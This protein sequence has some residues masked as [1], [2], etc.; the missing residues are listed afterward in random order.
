MATE[1]AGMERKAGRLNWRVALPL[2][3][4]AGLGG[5]LFMPL[6][7]VFQT[8]L[9]QSLL[10]ATHLPV[11]AVFVWAGRMLLE[12]AW[13]WPPARANAAA[14]AMIVLGA[15][16]VE[17]VQPKFGRS[18]S[19]ED[20]LIGVGGAALM[21]VSPWC[22]GRGRGRAIAW[23]AAVLIGCVIVLY[24][25]L[26]ELNAIRFR[27][28]QFPVLGDFEREEEL[29]Y[30]IPAG[31]LEPM[32]ELVSRS[33]DH[34]KTGQHSLKVR[35]V[36]GKWPGVFMTVGGQDWS[37]YDALALDLFNPGRQF[38]LGLRLDDDHP[39][40]EFWGYRYDGLFYPT[41]GWNHIEIPM[42]T[43]E[44]GGWRRGMNTRD[45]RRMI[46]FVDWKQKPCEWYLDN[47]RLIRRR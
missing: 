31:F 39:D 25:A 20:A 26:R 41:N 30:W 37:G 5:L 12:A 34:A 28:A 7:R 24:P 23:C 11:F 21:F 27:S 14:F 44:K 18:G 43:I 4:G 33:T 40:S 36:R 45:I 16:A 38:E 6:P 35:C 9:G 22:L 19:L 8:P 13:K 47:V 3:L 46:I 32:P 2:L 17:L 29:S 15:F 10:N 1:E 42:A